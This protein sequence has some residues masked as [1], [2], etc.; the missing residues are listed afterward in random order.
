MLVQLCHH[1][2]NN[3][4]APEAVARFLQALGGGVDGGPKGYE[5]RE[6]SPPSEPWRGWAKDIARL[7]L[8]AMQQWADSALLVRA[9]LWPKRLI[10]EIP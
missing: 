7:L 9:A 6:Q 1:A 2:R 3:P 4:A 10:P 5:K 8:S